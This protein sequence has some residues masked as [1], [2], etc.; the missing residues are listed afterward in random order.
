VRHDGGVELVSG[1]A[2]A[3]LAV[4]VLVTR[5]R[6]KRDGRPAGDEGPFRQLVE[7][8]DEARCHDCGG[9]VES[10]YLTGCDF[11]VWSPD[12]RQLRGRERL[13]DAGWRIV[14]HPALRCTACRLVWFEY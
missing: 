11:L 2:L 8:P 7:S 14:R 3:A 12:G 4:A 9:S 5:P 6:K 10:G 1:L 13:D